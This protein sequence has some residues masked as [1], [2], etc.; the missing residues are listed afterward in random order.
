MIFNEP[1]ENLCSSAESVGDKINHPWDTR[2]S[3]VGAWN[4]KIGEMLGCVGEK[5]YFCIRLAASQHNDQASSLFCVR[6]AQF[7]HKISCTSAIE[8]NFI[9]FDLH[10]FCSQNSLNV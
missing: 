7:L 3:S 9:A 1:E 6:F 5:M 2:E 4:L 10:D 8:A